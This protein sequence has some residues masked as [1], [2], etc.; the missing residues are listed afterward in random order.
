MLSRD[1][2]WQVST[3]GAVSRKARKEGAK[4]AAEEFLFL[5]EV[6]PLKVKKKYLG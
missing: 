5:H 3:P 2:P 1:L 6:I 4:L